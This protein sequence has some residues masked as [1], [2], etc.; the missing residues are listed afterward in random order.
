PR[1]CLRVNQWIQIFS[2]GDLSLIPEV[3]KNNELATKSKILSVEYVD[4]QDKILSIEERKMAL[5][6]RKASLLEKKSNAL[7]AIERV[8][9]IDCHLYTAM[10]ADFV[11]SIMPNNNNQIAY[12]NEEADIMANKDISTLYKEELGSI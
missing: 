5:E 11:N 7:V 3:V 9:T 10:K 4:I 2:S 1:L 8:K 12:N 6:E